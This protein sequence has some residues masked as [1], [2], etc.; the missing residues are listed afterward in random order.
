MNERSNV[1]TYVNIGDLK[2]YLVDGGPSQEI[3][4]HI[5]H[6]IGQIFILFLKDKK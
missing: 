5:I 2:N 3:N 1:I 4:K 6:I